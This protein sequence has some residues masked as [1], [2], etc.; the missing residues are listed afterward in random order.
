MQLEKSLDT[1]REVGVTRCV[2]EAF[3]LRAGVVRLDVRALGVGVR[4]FFR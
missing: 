2:A 4:G 1:D 3:P